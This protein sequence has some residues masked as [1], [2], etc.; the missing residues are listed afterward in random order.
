MDVLLYMAECRKLVP[1]SLDGRN[2][3]CPATIDSQLSQAR[4]KVHTS[5]HTQCYTGLIDMFP[6]GE[7]ECAMCMETLS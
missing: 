2:A 7:G 6:V 4:G 5:I 3:I 1:C